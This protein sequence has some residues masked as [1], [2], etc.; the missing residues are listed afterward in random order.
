MPTCLRV[1]GTRYTILHNSSATGTWY[2]VLVMCFFN[3]CC[4]VV[5]VVNL[6]L[7]KIINISCLISTRF[8]GHGTALTLPPPERDMG[9]GKKKKKKMSQGHSTTL[10]NKQPKNKNNDGDDEWD[11]ADQLQ[12]NVDLAVIQWEKSLTPGQHGLSWVSDF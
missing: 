1:P 11:L 12:M 9:K 8:V 10:R 4:P 5:Q 7:Y 2:L 3:L 6:N